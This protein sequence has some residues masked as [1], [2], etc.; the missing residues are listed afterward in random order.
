MT[1]LFSLA[2]HSIAQPVMRSRAAR[3]ELIATAH[4]NNRKHN[5]TGMLLF[6]EGAFVQ[7]LEGDEASVRALFARIERDTR[8]EQ[9]TLI[10]EAAVPKRA[11][12]FWSMALCEFEDENADAKAQI[13]CAINEARDLGLLTPLTALE[14]ILF[15][16]K[17]N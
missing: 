11:F 13:R 7:V 5:I 9:V 14:S 2:Y 17:R 3:K 4:V 15:R 12:S 10:C 6:A 16:M 8:H 1:Q